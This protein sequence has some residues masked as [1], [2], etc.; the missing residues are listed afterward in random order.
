MAKFKG[1]DFLIQV[2][3]GGDPTE[4]FTDLTAIRDNSMSING[5]QVD[6][7]DKGSSGWRELLAECG[8][9]SMS[10]AGSGVFSD[11]AQVALLQGHKLNRTHV[12]LK[13]TSG[14]GDEFAGT[15]EVASFERSST[16]NDAEQYSI[17]LESAGVIGYTAPT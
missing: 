7:T 4:N 13:I 10:L 3:D 5:E 6:I 9:N 16:Y 2:G 15:F 1:S 12:N 17:S 14:N 8:I 11:S